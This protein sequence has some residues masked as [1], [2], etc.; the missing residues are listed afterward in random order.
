MTPGKDIKLLMNQQWIA[1]VFLF[2]ML[3]LM[4]STA[5][6][7][8]NR[9]DFGIF[10]SSVPEQMEIRILPNYGENGTQYLT[11]AQF[12][13][14]WPVNS[15][16]S[17]L[18]SLS[19]ISPFYMMPQGL[20]SI[21]NGYYYQVWSTP[22]GNAVS[23]VG[24][25]EIVIQEFTYST[26]SCVIFEIAHDDYTQNV[27]NGDYYIEINGN[28]DLTGILYQPCSG[29]GIF[30]AGVI[31]GTDT[32]IAGTSNVSFSIFSIPHAVDYIWS[33]SGA[34]AT[35]N[36]NDTIISISFA[37][38]ATSGILSVAGHNINCGQG[39][40]SPDFY[41]TVTNTIGIADPDLNVAANHEIKIW[42]NPSEGNSVFLGIEN[43][44]GKKMYAEIVSF[45]S[46]TSNTIILHPES[47][48]FAISSLDVSG[49]SSGFYLIRVWV[50]NDLYIGKLIKN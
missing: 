44:T 46:K 23:W 21:Y 37:T 32:V 38:W 30:P 28:P 48:S 49:L 35:F 42:P 50:D 45:L 43:S 20:P 11:N 4:K 19:G 14:R 40:V 36:G 18:I 13:V 25:Q 6:F 41:I 10:T 8:Q 3:V 22:G 9:I 33:Y 5:L 15:G 31:S 29:P 27:I 26:D 34:G 24:N 16:V 2:I 12:T 7:G 17:S 1:I 47:G 39:T